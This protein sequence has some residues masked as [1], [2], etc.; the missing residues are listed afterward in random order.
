[1]NRLQQERDNIA[2][3]DLLT[4][5]WIAA[6]ARARNAELWRKP[7]TLHNCGL[8]EGQES[9]VTLRL[10]AKWITYTD[11]NREPAQVTEDVW[12]LLDQRSM[13][14][15]D[16]SAVR[17]LIRASAVTGRLMRYMDRADLDGAALAI[18][19]QM[20]TPLLRALWCC[21]PDWRN[22]PHEE[23][24]TPAE[25]ANELA[26]T[27]WQC[28]DSYRRLLCDIAKER[29]NDVLLQDQGKRVFDML[30]DSGEHVFLRQA[31]EIKA[32]EM[33]ECLHETD[34]AER[35]GVI[36]NLLHF[37][38]RIQRPDLCNRLSARLR[39]ARI[40]YLSS[41]E[42]V[43]KPLTQWFDLMR[44]ARSSAW[45]NEGLQLLELDRICE[46]QGGEN[47]FSDQ[48]IAS[49]AAAAMESGAGDFEALFGLLAARGV[50]NCLWTLAK[51]A[52]DGFGVCL[53]EE[54]LMNEETALARM[55][56]AI[57]LG[58]WPADTALKTVCGLLTD[59]GMSHSLVEQPVWQKA[60]RI[61]VGMQG[62]PVPPHFG[63]ASTVRQSEVGESRSAAAILHQILHPEGNSWLRLEEIAN[64]ARQ[65]YAE[66]HPERAS[67]VAKALDALE[68]ST[69]P[70]SRSLEFYNSGLMAQFYKYLDEPELWRLLGLLTAI[71]GDLRQK[72]NTDSN[73]AFMVAF[74]AVDRTC[75]ARAERAGEG[76]SV[77]TFH[78]LLAMHWKWHGIFAQPPSLI[79]GN[80]TTFWPDAV[81]RM[82]LSLTHTD[83]CETVYMA[84][85]GLRFFAEC[86]PGQIPA[87]C[88][89]GLRD[90]EARDA[91]LPL[92]QMWAT[93][94]PREISP[95]LP[96][97]EDHEAIGTLDERLDAWAVSALH[98]ITTGKRP[99][100]IKLPE[101]DQVPQIGFPG[102]GP[103]FEGETM[104]DGLFRHNSFAKM[105]NMRVKR[106]G[107][108]LGPMSHAYR[109]MALAVRS[110]AIEFPSINLPRPKKLAFHSSSPR[111]LHPSDSL[112]G[113]AIINQCAGVV[114]PPAEAAAVRLLIG[115]G[116]DPWIVSAPPNAWPDES[117]WPS[118]YDLEHGNAGISIGEFARNPQ[119][120]ALL[121]GVDLDP[122]LLLL[123]AVLRIPTFRRDLRFELWLDAPEQSE[124]DFGLKPATRACRTLASWLAGYSFASSKR[125]GMSSVY[126]AG[127]L[128][129]YPNSDLDVTP[130]DHWKK[131]WGW[132]P[133]ASNPL[134]FKS[135]NGKTAAWFERWIGPNSSNRSVCRQPILSRWVA[136][137]DS[138]P[139]HE[140]AL[141]RWSRRTEFSTNDLLNPE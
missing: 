136:R 29:F 66:G 103:L 85:C 102:D 96:L 121:H 38:Q 72:L 7:L 73:W 123:G 58:G 59:N 2:D 105:A 108:I 3:I 70:L 14:S 51:A 17:V 87:I 120:N 44:K 40:G 20:L 104:M 69:E 97:F 75:L 80:P 57:S 115:L 8:A 132:T 34:V 65:A 110:G 129:N 131:G 84:M 90:E 133:D 50:K 39:V 140:N 23:L 125:S 109:H 68:A 113:D 119:L 118:E 126:F 33:V 31:V 112:A 130:T 83:S 13:D 94:H 62:V 63:E 28:G 74:S 134:R 49:V 11:I 9:L 18:S 95:S 35:G 71:T 106:A 27:A 37:S 46:Q 54:H 32:C 55:A 53:Q 98:S 135:N 107:L 82:L 79:V 15:R 30:W 4:L 100:G 141:E 139:T 77:A 5:G 42:W 93:S 124:D 41:K 61:T 36:A 116:V 21:R 47:G 1:L 117:S 99:R 81:R 6:R 10:V 101:N 56:L 60:L 64:L 22:L 24:R 12:P 111:H 26:E 25:V 128:V 19:P 16:P 89:E 91:V 122:S 67:L 137:R 48:L 52:Q 86:F 43:F 88:R 92:A 127:S 76:F 45:S 78:Q 138:F 114:W